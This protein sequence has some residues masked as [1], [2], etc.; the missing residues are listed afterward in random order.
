MTKMPK[1]AGV[2]RARNFFNGRVKKRIVAV[3][4]ADVLSFYIH[5]RYS[6][7]VSIVRRNAAY[8]K[9]APRQWRGCWL[10][11]TLISPHA[12]V[13]V[14]PRTSRR[15][16]GYTTTHTEG[17]RVTAE[18]RRGGL[19]SGV[20]PRACVCVRARV[21]ITTNIHIHIHTCSYSIAWSRVAARAHTH[22]PPSQTTTTVHT[23]TG[24]LAQMQQKRKGGAHA[25]RTHR[26]QTLPLPWSTPPH[27]YPPIYQSKVLTKP[28][29]GKEKPPPHFNST[30]D[31][32]FPL[33]D[34]LSQIS[35]QTPLPGVNQSIEGPHKAT[36]GHGE[37]TSQHHRGQQTLRHDWQE[38]H[39]PLY[40][41]QRRNASGN[42]HIHI[43]VYR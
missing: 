7:S 33:R 8:V 3:F 38:V 9:V 41:L 27:R 11:L 24:L 17:S 26:F 29:T 43:H 23:N 21:P 1:C 6:Y 34:P 28:H 15:S 30:P 35:Q 2:T 37:A 4:I 18:T 5:I 32:R 13:R 39:T 22:T 16:F 14:G 25:R 20:V 36:H 19:R 42:V 31:E 10:L 40:T 12:Q